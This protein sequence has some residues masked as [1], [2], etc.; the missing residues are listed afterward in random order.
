MEQEDAW[1]LNCSAVTKYLAKARGFV[2]ESRHADDWV[3]YSDVG[4]SFPGGVLSFEEYLAVEN[5][6]VDAVMAFWSF[7]KVEEIVVRNLEVHYLGQEINRSEDKLLVEYL[8]TCPWHRK[9]SSFESKLLVRSVLRNLIFCSL[10]DMSG[11]FQVRFGWD[12]YMYFVP[13]IEDTKLSKE[14]VE[15]G[16]Y[17][18]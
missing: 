4:K 5:A 10:E 16:L 1:R 8:I 7:Q 6:Y 18:S 14:I 11:T 3:D 15:L 13:E 9:I 12:Y 17:V 2:T